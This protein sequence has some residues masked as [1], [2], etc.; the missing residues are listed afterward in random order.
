MH[1]PTHARTHTRTHPHTHTHTPTHAPTHARTPARTGAPRR[2]DAASVCM[3]REAAML[4]RSAWS[5]RRGPGEAV[6]AAGAARWGDAAVRTPG[7][8]RLSVCA[9]WSGSSFVEVSPSAPPSLSVLPSLTA[10]PDAGAAGPPHRSHP[11]SQARVPLPARDAR[12]GPCRVAL[13]SASPPQPGSGASVTRSSVRQW[14][15]GQPRH[16][17]ACGDG[18]STRRWER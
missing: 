14:E 7:P 2:S 16:E 13:S 18:V 8:A 6:V 10:A 3:V 9:P 4:P 5:G 12:T 15:T 11:A 17:V 1:A